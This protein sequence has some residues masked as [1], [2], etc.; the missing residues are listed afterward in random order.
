MSPSAQA[1]DPAG[2]KNHNEEKPGDL[3]ASI[4]RYYVS[5]EFSD[6]TVHT[7]IQEFKVHRLVVCGQS[8]F[9]SRLYKNEWAENMKNE[10]NIYEDDPHAIE[11]MFRSMYGLE[12]DSRAGDHTSSLIFAIKA[13]QVA[14]KYL[15]SR[16]KTRAVER[17]RALVEKCWQTDDFHD[18]RI[19]IAEVSERTRRD[20]DLWR[21]LTRISADY[22]A[23]LGDNESFRNALED[24]NGF[25]ADLVLEMARNGIGKASDLMRKYRC[26]FERLTANQATA[27]MIPLIT[28]EEHY[29]SR[30]MSAASPEAQAQ[31][32]A[33]PPHI[34]NKL[35]SLGD[36]RIQDLDKGNVSLQIL[37]HGPG[38]IA[39]PLCTAVND[40]LAAAVSQHPTRLA[41]FAM[42]PMSEPLAAATELERCVKELGFVGAL[43]ENHTGGKYYDDE[44]FWPVFEKAQELDVPLYIHPTFA[45]DPMMEYYKGNYDD[46]VALALSAYGWAWHTETAL[47]ILR[48]YAG[49]VFDRYPK[50]K[51]VIGHMGEML[52]FQL[53]RVFTVSARFGK[54]R[55]FQEVWRNNI[56]V[57]TSGMFSLTPLACL[58]KTTSIEHVLYSVDYPFSTNERGLD[59]FKEIEKSGLIAGEDLELFAYRNAEKLLRVT[60]KK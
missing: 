58:L 54:E 16:L 23:G 46:S 51:I 32:A 36:E 59:F 41:G 25:A 44:R 31:Y 52:P 21:I 8:E 19:I 4:K 48:L 49:G 37:S 15:V 7:K 18:F 42:L 6:L 26:K 1:V 13:Y 10:V 12:Y 60:A 24:S 28:L 47:H 34:R 56:W 3:V 9:F 2:G 50:L 14:D 27:I 43:I 53:D 17:F 45:T 29:S 39:A 22:I 38:D 55:S 11:A 30:K 20:Q 57:T 40:D 5:S 33:F 35:E